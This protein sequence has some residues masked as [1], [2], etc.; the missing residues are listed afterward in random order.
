VIFTKKKT[1]GRKWIIVLSYF[2]Q[3]QRFSAR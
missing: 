3:K 1:N 2:S